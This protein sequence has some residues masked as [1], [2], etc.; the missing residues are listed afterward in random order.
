MGMSWV[1]R[2]Q[3]NQAPFR[4]LDRGAQDCVC[5]VRDISTAEFGSVEGQEGDF[6]TV[7][8]GFF[9]SVDCC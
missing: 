6:Y 2:G 4:R 1:F 3:L 5:R 8:H 9:C 7:L